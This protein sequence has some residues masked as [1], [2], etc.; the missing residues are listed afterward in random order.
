VSILTPPRSRGIEILDDPNVDRLVRRQSQ[1]DVARSNRVLGGLRAMLVEIRAALRELGNEATLL[2]VGTGIADIPAEA[3][4]L[5]Q[6][7]HIRLSATGVDVAHSLLAEECGE[8]DHG[9]CAD[10][11]RLPF[12]D[13]SFDIVT[14][15][16]L[17]HHFTAGEARVIIAEL[18]RV[19]RYAVIV[20]DLR[21]SWV[22]AGGFWLLSFPL[23]F[24]RVT[25]HDGS[26]SVLRGFTRDELRR[27]IADATGVEPRVR[28]R[29]GYRLT[30]RWHPATATADPSDPHELGPLPVGRRMTTVDERI[31]RAPLAEIF[32][33][34]RHVERWPAVL[35]H[36]RYVRFRARTRDAGGLVDMS[37]NRP[38]GPLPWPTR[39]TSLMSVHHPGNGSEPSIRFRHVGGVTTG[40][41]VAWT[42]QPAGPDTL[43]RIVHVWNGPRWPMIGAIA[44]RAII[45]PIFVHGI[46]SRTLAGLAA[47]AERIGAATD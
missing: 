32:A 12:A 35:P 46:A 9:V 17:L 34:A 41:D 1:H 7:S 27:M 37:A 29:L 22:A 14:C 28:T 24:H 40:M 43:V 23:R 45:G 42:F 4:R 13:R 36:Y 31:V 30:A 47:A 15:S 6:R 21:R 3:T 20:S 2:D 11:R 26:T 5:A 39:W 18:D 16:Q 38:F 25:R 44:A 33:L 10:A 19:A 8:I